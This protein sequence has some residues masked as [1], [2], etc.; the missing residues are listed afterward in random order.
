MNPIGGIVQPVKVYHICREAVIQPLS[1][2]L[3]SLFVKPP[4]SSGGMFPAIT[5]TRVPLLPRSGKSLRV[6]DTLVDCRANVSNRLAPC[7]SKK[8]RTWVNMRVLRGCHTRQ[9]LPSRRQSI[10][11]PPNSFAFR[12]ACQLASSRKFTSHGHQC[13][14]PRYSLYLPCP[15]CRYHFGYEPLYLRG[16]EVFKASPVRYQVAQPLFPQRRDT[17]RMLP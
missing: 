9:R 11:G 10:C 2:L 1:R 7:V 8:P 17:W 5:E 4:A 14:A 13:K 15:M 16:D 3:N 6:F 12:P